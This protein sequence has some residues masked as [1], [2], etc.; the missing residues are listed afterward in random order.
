MQILEPWQILKIFLGFRHIVAKRVLLLYN[1]IEIS[2]IW[3]GT[4]CRLRQINLASGIK[5]IW[6]SLFQAMRFFLWF[7]A[8]LWTVW[9]T[10]RHSFWHRECIIMIWR[11][12]LIGQCLL[13]R[14]GSAFIFSVTLFGWLAMLWHQNIIPKN[15]GIGSFLPISLP[16]SS[17]ASS[18]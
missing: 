13:Y 10:G 15:F 12:L 18:L 1:Y 7:R 16:E 11:P 6:R 5:R 4:L 3:V 8:L 9:F 17:A 14:N 2:D